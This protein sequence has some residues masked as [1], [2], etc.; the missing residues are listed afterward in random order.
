M[1]GSRRKIDLGPGRS[2]FGTIVESSN[3][4]PEIVRDCYQ[5]HLDRLSGDGYVLTIGDIQSIA[6][7]RWGL[8]T[9]GGPPQWR[10]R[11]QAAK[12]TNAQ[13]AKG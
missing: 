5:R 10:Q 3:W 8:G 6:R 1:D 12:P 4:A 13:E 7:T 9:Q 2:L 11:T